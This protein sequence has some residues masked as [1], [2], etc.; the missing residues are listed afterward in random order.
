MTYPQY[1]QPQG[2]APQAPYQPQPQYQPTG[3]ATLPA[4]PPPLATGGAGGGAWPKMRHLQDCTIIIEPIRVD[5]TKIATLG[6]QK[7]QPQPETSR[8]RTS[9][10]T[11]T[12]SAP[13]WRRCSR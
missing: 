2:Y 9:A 10:R 11:A 12:D 3:G 1:Q 5:E 6:A 13:S 8:Q 4:I 7:G